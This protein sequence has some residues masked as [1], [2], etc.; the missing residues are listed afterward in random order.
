MLVAVIGTAVAIGTGV[1]GLSVM[2]GLLSSA[3]PA[4]PEPTASA[5][6]TPSP[7]PLTPVEIDAIRWWIAS[8]ASDTLTLGQASNV[9]D[10]VKALAQ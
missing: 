2:P 8:G 5:S 9:P 4:E 3:P 1:V 6:P 7:T 10:G